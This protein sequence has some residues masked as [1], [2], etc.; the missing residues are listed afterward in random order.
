MPIQLPELTK[1]YYTTN[2]TARLFGVAPTTIR[3]WEE[4][5]TI[6]RTH[7]FG[8]GERRFTVEHIRLLQKIH[9]LVKERGF[10]IEGAK[11]EINAHKSWYRDKDKM[12]ERLRK[13]KSSL[14]EIREG[15]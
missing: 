7:K 9:F 2:E 5:F 15:I 14:E 11:R 8:N 3:H 1:R 13:I 4:K 12:L 6:L 10:T